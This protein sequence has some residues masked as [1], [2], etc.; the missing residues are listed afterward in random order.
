MAAILD[1]SREGAFVSGCVPP[2]PKAVISITTPTEVIRRRCTIRRSP[3]PGP[4]EWAA[5]QFV[6]P[7]TDGEMAAVV[8]QPPSA[9]AQQAPQH[10]VDHVISDIREIREEIR[11]IQECRSHVFLATLGAM[12]AALVAIAGWALDGKLS[13]PGVFYGISI[14]FGLFLIGILSTVE[15]ARGLNLRMG[16][17]KCLTLRFLRMDIPAGYPGWAILK[18]T[19]LECGARR[20]LLICNR[21]CSPKSRQTCRDEAERDASRTNSVQRFTPGILESFMSLSATVYAA[22]YLAIMIAMA[23]Y[24]AQSFGVSWGI[25]AIHVWL[26]YWVGVMVSPFIILFKRAVFLMLTGFA[27]AVVFNA[28]W[29]NTITGY[30]ICFLIG[31]SLGAVGWFLIRQ[32]NACKRGKLASNTFFYL[33]NRML[34]CCSPVVPRPRSLEMPADAR[35]RAK[36]ARFFARITA[37]LL[38]QSPV[39]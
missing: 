14:S 9:R 16:M 26:L 29:A 24:L 37:R 11:S 30:V 7:L 18:Y 31:A 17:L 8:P 1:V 12:A 19:I 34:D 38:G 35:L 32:M 3:T 21:G 33:W 27:A 22:I 6:V 39:A 10:V 2:G 36:I 25:P 5:V 28:L 23:H 4:G 13:P 20:K 15:K